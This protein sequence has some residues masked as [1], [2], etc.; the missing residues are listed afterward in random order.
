MFA[1]FET[2]GMLERPKIVIS[3]VNDTNVLIYEITAK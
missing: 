1:F 2:I 3:M